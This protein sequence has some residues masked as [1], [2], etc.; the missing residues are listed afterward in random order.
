VILNGQPD[1]AVLRDGC[2]PRQGSGEAF[3]L[4]VQRRLLQPPPAV[5][6]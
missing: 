6:V 4:L 1:A 2:E 5:Q 3:Q